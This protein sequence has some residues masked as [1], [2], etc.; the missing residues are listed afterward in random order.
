GG[1][2]EV[3]GTLHR[4]PP[5]LADPPTPQGVVRVHLRGARDLRS[6]DRFMGGLVEGKS[7]P[8]AVLRVGT[9]VVTSRVI[10][11]NLNP[12]W[13][14]VYEFIVHE[15][16]GQEMEVELFDKDPDQDDLLGRVC[17]GGRGGH[18]DP[19]APQWFPLQEGGQGRLHLRLEWLS[20]M[21][22]ASK[23]DQVLERNRT[24]VAKPDPPSA[25]ILVVYLDRA[26]DLPVSGGPGG[27]GLPV[28]CSVG[29]EMCGAPPDAPPFFADEEAG[30]GAQPH[31]AGLS[32]GC[33]TGE[34]G[35]PGGP[36][37]AGAAPQ[38]GL[39]CRGWAGWWGSNPASPRWSITHLLPSGKMLSASSCTTPSVSLAGGDAAP[40]PA[41]APGEECGTGGLRQRLLP[42]DSHPEPAEGPLGRL[43]L[44][45][46]YYGEERK[47]VA[48]VHACRKLRA[49]SKELPDP[50][51]SLVLLPDRS[52]STKRK[53]SVQKKTL[54]PDFNERF[55]W[56]VSLEEASRRKLEANV[57]STVSFMSRE[58]EVLGKIHL[59]LAQV[60][61]SEGGTHW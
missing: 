26:E 24:I 37:L 17:W 55:E 57:K 6:K 16:P 8:Y 34:Q 60:D 51:V 25:A 2:G 4:A 14:E 29:S 31:G 59:D 49:V 3:G 44:T 52:R 19:F 35:G 50:Y 13:D 39:G 22:D 32:A 48:I 43:Q 56:D 36:S 42:A 30:Q 12:T 53:T 33:H 11:D 21:S 45:L 23:L 15:V 7:D 41:E 54:N 27:P 18:A 38:L 1:P 61:L 20:L 58:K 46:W 5:S 40:Q 28:P 9:Q 10:D 47:L